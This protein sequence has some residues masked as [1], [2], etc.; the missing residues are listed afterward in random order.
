MEIQALLSHGAEKVLKDLKLI[1][2]QKNDQFWRQLKLGQTPVMPGTPL[3]YN[4]FKELIRASGVN[5]RENK[6]GDHIF[7][8][9]GKQAEE[10]TGAREIKNAGTYGSTSLRPIEGGLF[11]PKA[12]GSLGDGNRWSYIKLPEPMVNPIME[13]PIRTL[14]GKTQKEFDEVLFGNVE[15]GGKRGAAAVQQMLQKINIPTAKQIALEEIKHGAKS[16]RNKA[17]KQFQYLSAM[18]K[19]GVRPE[20]F[21]MDRVPVLPPKYR[22]ITRTSDMTI[23]ADPNYMYKA[24]L[25]SSKDL[26]ESAGLPQVFRNQAR[27]AM[28]KNYRSLVGLSDPTQAKLKQKNVSGILSQL[29]GK[30]SPKSGFVQRR[31]IGADIEVSGLAVVTPNPSL[32]LNEV[33]LPEAKAWELYEP[34][35][36]RHL[37]QRGVPATAAAKAVADKQKN[38]YAALREVVKE[39]PVVV[40]RAPTLHKYSMYAAWPVLTKG[41]TLQV[42]PSI[43]KPMAMDFDGDTASYS[44]PVSK[45]AV[46]EAIQ[47]M[48]PEKNLINSRND[49]PTYT[50]NNEYVQGLWLATKQPANKAPKRFPDKA[51]AMAA[52]KAGAIRIDDP[53]VIG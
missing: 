16:K 34:F 47:K 25:E 51:A 33:G 5:L 39:R 42:S 28:V 35:I 53:I 30:G 37:V 49:R 7:A 9:T 3:V 23:V 13:E 38:A 14:L 1:K 45:A 27:E 11:D 46:E 29:F 36:I 20:D 48:M 21:I 10:L 43:V 8:M 17:V 22:P 12:T 4:K 24:L 50:P 44:V 52:Y 19:Q 40:N 2:G 32:K 18:E 26:K 15:V 31:V 41:E 6:T